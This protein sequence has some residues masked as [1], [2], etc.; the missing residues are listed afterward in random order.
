MSSF[1]P[2][3]GEKVEV[4][5]PEFRTGEVDEALA[6]F[7]GAKAQNSIGCAF[8]GMIKALVSNDVRQ[9]S[10][11][12]M[13]INAFAQG[14]KKDA[15][16]PEATS[17]ING[18]SFKEALKENPTDFLINLAGLIT[19]KNDINKF[20]G[21]SYA[22]GFDFEF[23]FPEFETKAWS[24]TNKITTFAQAKKVIKN[25]TVTCAQKAGFSS[26]EELRTAIRKDADLWSVEDF[27]K[28][29][30]FFL[31]YSE[32]AF[33]FRG[34][35]HHREPGLLASQLEGKYLAIFT[36]LMERI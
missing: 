26:F 10:E 9:A 29:S 23:N 8:N 15:I 30:L 21:F 7:K 34:L 25:D 12:A 11:A 19:S 22:L 5:K 17:L 32:M 14:V 36:L 3:S 1:R 20:V 13:A 33:A 35:T 6:Y 31:E 28:V 24:D 4:T 18:Q 2:S 16:L 27:E